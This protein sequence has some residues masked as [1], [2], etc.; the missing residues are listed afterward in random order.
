MLMA[1]MAVFLDMKEK[2]A[3][4][5]QMTVLLP[6]APTMELAWMESMTFNA[7]AFRV[8]LEKLVKSTLMTVLPIPV[9]IMQCH[10]WMES[11]TFNVTA[12]QVLLEK[13]VK[14]TWMTV[15]LLLAPIMELAWMES[16]T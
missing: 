6:L 2:I 7:T 14:S 4:S 15:L 12:F 3:K 13:H 5:T 16:M 1:T 11:M 8:L 10:V 9:Q